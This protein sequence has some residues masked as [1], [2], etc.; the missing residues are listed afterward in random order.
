MKCNVKINKIT[1]CILKYIN[2]G[3]LLLIGFMLFCIIVIFIQ[4]LSGDGWRFALNI[5]GI[6]NMLDYW[7]QYNQIF[8]TLGWSLTLFVASINLQRYINVESIRSLTDLRKMLNSDE[9]KKIHHY[10]LNENKKEAILKDLE[11]SEDSEKYN[12]IIHSNIEVYDYLGTLEQGVIMVEKGL[13]SVDE[14]NQQFGYRIRSILKNETLMEYIMGHGY[15]K[16]KDIMN[17]S[18]IH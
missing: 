7:N 3:L 11:F 13:I 9:K 10:L 17:L 5:S 4:E 16:L 2:I 6:N 1:S 18:K 14:F 15:K 8:K 12:K